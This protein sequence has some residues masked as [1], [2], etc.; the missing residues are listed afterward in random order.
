MY[1][2]YKSH[3]LAVQGRCTPPGRDERLCQT[4]FLPPA[5]KSYS[6]AQKRFTLRKK[7]V[8]KKTADR[9]NDAPPTKK[10]N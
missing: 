8:D 5:S 6:Q 2:Q 3:V 9:L 4:G 7:I 10:Y 1:S